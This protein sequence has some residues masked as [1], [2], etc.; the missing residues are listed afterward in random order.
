MDTM[1]KK[2]KRDE[3]APHGRKSPSTKELLDFSPREGTLDWPALHLRFTSPSTDKDARGRALTKMYTYLINVRATDI[4]WDAIVQEGKEGNEENACGDS[5]LYATI[6]ERYIERI[7]IQCH[8]LHLHFERNKR[9]PRLVLAEIL[10]M[11]QRLALHSQQQQ[12]EDG[13]GKH[14]DR[15]RG[16][17]ERNGEAHE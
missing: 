4:S 12:K 3:G 13:E 16:E 2:K 5:P 17:G 10:E 6:A 7:R 8:K 14:G 11:A 1:T 9:P 15:D